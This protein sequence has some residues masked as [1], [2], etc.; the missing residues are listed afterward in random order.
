MNNGN[1]PRRLIPQKQTADLVSKVDR[2]SAVSGML[3]RALGIID[4][5]LIKL[6]AKSRSNGG[7]LDEKETRALHGHIKAL[8][9]LSKEEREREKSDK[10]PEDLQNL[11]DEQL[12]ELA[13]KKLVTAKDTKP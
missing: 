12:L 1:P 11:T 9:D 8:V 3:D 2:V 5:Q 4:E 7:M 6:G 13:N 10:T